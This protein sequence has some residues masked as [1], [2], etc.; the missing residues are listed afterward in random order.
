MIKMH[1]LTPFFAAITLLHGCAV[2][3]DWVATGGSRA[4]GTVRL[5]Y[6]YGVLQKPQVSDAQGRILAAERCQAWGYED[7]EP[8]GGILTNCATSDGLGGCRVFMVTAEYQC[9][10]DL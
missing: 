1:S 9:L 6:Q 4:D 10:G 5:S 2:Q 8:F 7:T 3:K